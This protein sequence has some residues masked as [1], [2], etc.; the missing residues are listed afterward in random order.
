MPTTVVPGSSTSNGDWVSAPITCG[1]EPTLQTSSTARWGSG[2]DVW[3]GV[4]ADLLAPDR[5]GE[6]AQ[7]RDGRA[8]DVAL[9]PTA[10]AENASPVT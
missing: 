3:R 9:P 4:A 2:V 5:G 1:V 8:L 6:L 10:G 7:R